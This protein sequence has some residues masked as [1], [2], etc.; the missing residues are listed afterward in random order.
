MWGHATPAMLY[1]LSMLSDFTPRRVAA[2]I[3]VDLLMLATVV[4]GELWPSWHRW[5][6]SAASCACYPYVF[7]ELWHMHTAAIGEGREAGTRAALRWMR[8]LTVTFWS[9][10]P[11]IWAAVQVR[12][13][14][15]WGSAQWEWGERK[16]RL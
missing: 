15:R 4:P 16:R 13:G 2:A 8:N 9:V 10:F 14:P 11:L 3:G 6:W 12:G 1:A 5:L 7:H